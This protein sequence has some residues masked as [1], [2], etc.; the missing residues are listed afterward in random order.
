MSQRTSN[1]DLRFSLKGNLVLIRQRVGN[2]FT[3]LGLKEARRIHS[4][5]GRYIEMRERSKSTSEGEKDGQER[6]ETLSQEV[7]D[8]PSIV[9]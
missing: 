1:F 2:D 3:S 9:A 5:L 6:Q 8:T 7:K 4:W